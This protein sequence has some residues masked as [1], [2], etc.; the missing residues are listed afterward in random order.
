[1]ILNKH[2]FSASDLEITNFLIDFFRNEGLIDIQAD[3]ESFNP[4][5]IRLE[6]KNLVLEFYNVPETSDCEHQIQITNLLLQGEF[7]RK[8]IS[9]RLVSSL[10]E[11]CSNHGDMCVLILGIINEYWLNSL[12]NHGAYLFEEDFN[13]SNLC[14]T[15]QIW[16][17]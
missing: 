11:Y 12:L 9:K 13:G 15:P 8:G 3:V 5:K 10:M 6:N 7:N 2:F 16:K 17:A 1:M 14:I 4:T